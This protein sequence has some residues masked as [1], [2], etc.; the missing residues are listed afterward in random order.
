M[1]G[2]C[3]AL[4]ARKRGGLGGAII[5]KIRMRSWKVIALVVVALVAV[6]VACPLFT[7]WRMMVSPLHNLAT[8]A[9]WAVTILIIVVFVLSL[10]GRGAPGTRGRGKGPEALDILKERYARGEISR[11]EF[12]RMKRDIEL[13]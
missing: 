1:R 3:Q 10:V 8:F 2:D 6:L 5:R 13:S 9:F 12:E 11:E 4:K 7:A